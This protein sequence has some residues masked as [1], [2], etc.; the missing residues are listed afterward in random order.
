MARQKSSGW[1]VKK[2]VDIKLGHNQG[3]IFVGFTTVRSYFAA[4]VL[5]FGMAGAV[6]AIWFAPVVLPALGVAITGL[7]LYCA[8]IIGAV[9][10][11]FLAGSFFKQWFGDNVGGNGVIKSPW[12]VK[13]STEQLN[14]QMKGVGAGDIK[15]RLDGYNST[16]RF[17]PTDKTKTYKINVESSWRLLGK[18]FGGVAGAAAATTLGWFYQGAILAFLGLSASSVVMAFMPL[19]LMTAGLVVG[20]VAFYL[21]GRVADAM[22]SR[23][24]VIDTFRAMPRVSCDAFRLTMRTVPSQS[25]NSGGKLAKDVR[26]DP[27]KEFGGRVLTVYSK[28]V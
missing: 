26:L 10:V 21:F 18:Y 8:T 25:D 3:Q 2:P 6:A 12:G 1:F 7:S 13:L 4:V 11:S 28:G 20:G 19:V 17:G 23:S 14:K 15:V 24:W 5:T 16:L 22:A 9:V 27:D